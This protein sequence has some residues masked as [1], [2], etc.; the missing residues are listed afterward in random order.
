MPPI[1]RA[2]MSFDQTGWSIGTW[3]VESG[4]PK[5][6]TRQGCVS[7]RQRNPT[8]FAHKD[9]VP[10]GRPRR[11]AGTSAGCR[12]WTHACIDRQRSGK[13]PCGSEAQPRPRRN[14]PEGLGLAS[15]LAVDHPRHVRGGVEAGLAAPVQ[16]L[17]PGLVAVPVAD[18]V[19]IAWS[20]AGGTSVPVMSRRSFLRFQG[21][22]ELGTYRRR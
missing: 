6:R 7:T 14:G 2:S 12:L 22:G 17:G 5:K 9:G 13:W 3:S 18:K 15:R 20:L 1:H 16:A 8:P 10:C 11:R 21:A 19:G 4:Q